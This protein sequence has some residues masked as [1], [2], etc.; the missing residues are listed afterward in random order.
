[1]NNTKV[2]TAGA[3]SARVRAELS[4]GIS[5][6]GIYGM[7]AALL[8][9]QRSRANVLV[10]VGCGTGELARVLGG[11][12]GVYI[13][14]DIVRYSEFP[15]NL[16]FVA[17]DLDSGRIRLEDACADVVVAVETIEHVENPRAFVRE[18]SRLCKPGGIILISTPNQLSLLSKLT[19]MLK[20]QFNAFQDACYP[21]HITALLESDLRR[22]FT[23]AG[24]GELSV[25][26]SKQGRI[27]GA[28]WHYP[29]FA[30]HWF[31]RMCSDN[32]AICGVKS[33]A[34]A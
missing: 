8:R 34:G 25:R 27:P 30:S 26:F 33:S 29:R 28:K 18:I 7:V 21:A 24:L 11:Y 9:A 22:I 16:S 32:I 19:L 2:N 14:V 15:T 23:E 10:D 17:T 12:Y 3:A 1:M 5:A 20:H 4:K 31:P 6:S 13:G